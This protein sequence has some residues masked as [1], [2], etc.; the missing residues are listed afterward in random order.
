ML[1]LV[2]LLGLIAVLTA[3]ERR[4]LGNVARD[5]LVSMVEGQATMIEL[6][7]PEDAQNLELSDLR[8]DQFDAN[9]MRR[10]RARSA[11]SEATAR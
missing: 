9:A 10:F 5:S 11:S 6:S 1:S 7:L 2:V 4:Y 8:L 3:H